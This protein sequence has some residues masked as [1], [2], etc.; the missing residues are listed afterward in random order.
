VIEGAPD[1]DA[2]AGLRRWTA[3]ARSG[4]AGFWMQ[5]SHAGRQTPSAINPTPRSPSAVAV[6]LPGKR[7]GQP[8]ALS[9]REIG[10]LIQRFA[11]VAGVAREAGQ[12]C[13]A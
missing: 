10:E 12:Q 13:A 9:E 3:A 8:V 7:F 4:G 5:L 2:M 11:R 1:A 6:A